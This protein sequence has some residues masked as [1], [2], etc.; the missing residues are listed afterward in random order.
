MQSNP[1]REKMNPWFYYY[2]SCCLYCASEG[3]WNNRPNTHGNAK[4]VTLRSHRTGK[5]G[6]GRKATLNRIKNN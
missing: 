1:N 3:Q 2:G 4:R 5:V 6:G